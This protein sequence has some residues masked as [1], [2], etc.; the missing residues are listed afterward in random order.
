MQYQLSRVIAG[1]LLHALGRPK[2]VGKDNVPASGGAIL[3]SNHLSVIDSVYLP[4]MLDRPVTF[5]AKAEYFTARGPMARLWAAYLRAT[6][7]LRIDRD[8]ARA[9]QATLEAALDLLREGKLFGFYPEGTRSPD[10]R[11]YRGRSGIG[12]LALKSGVPVVP[13]AMIGTRKVLP[14]GRLV[15]RPGQIEVR[16]GMPLTFGA[17]ADEAPAKARRA[18]ADQVMKAIQALSG[19]EYVAMYA[20]DRKAELAEDGG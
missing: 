9:A 7:Q 1:P 3:A 20:S 19:Q 6:N 17:L 14:P 13:V 11:L 16:I 8:G 2:I 12:W 15:P 18:V 5:P 4:L 10:G